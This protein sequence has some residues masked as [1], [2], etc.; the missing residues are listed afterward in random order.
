MKQVRSGVHRVLLF[1]KAQHSLKLI[2]YLRLCYSVGRGKIVSF[3]HQTLLRLQLRAHV[4]RA[5]AHSEHKLASSVIDESTTND[6]F[7]LSIDNQEEIARLNS[8]LN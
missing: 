7:L 3:I 5:T 1:T 6:E 4:Q 2:V 8:I